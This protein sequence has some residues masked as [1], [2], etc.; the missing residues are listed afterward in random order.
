MN[1]GAGTAQLASDVS[2]AIQETGSMSARLESRIQLS[3]NCF[4]A[5]CLGRPGYLGRPRGLLAS[6]RR[7]SWLYA[8][9]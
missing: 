4:R 7:A 8:T 5:A 6:W 3:P 1:R 9:P 2:S